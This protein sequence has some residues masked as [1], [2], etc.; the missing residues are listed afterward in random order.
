MVAATTEDL[1][2]SLEMARSRFLYGLDKTDPERLNW[3]PGGA[4]KTPLELAGKIAVYLGFLN[5]ILTGAPMP[6]RRGELPPAPESLEAAK[7]VVDGAFGALIDGVA[8]LTEADLERTFIP[9]WRKETTVREF[10]WGVPS[11]VA[12]H[13]GQ[14]NYVQMAY[15][16]TDPNIPPDWFPKE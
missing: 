10:L 7:S 9:P 11:V 2:T 15:G 12:Y 5:I 8:G 3:S 14:L 13:I 16:D 1:V 4:A 6:E